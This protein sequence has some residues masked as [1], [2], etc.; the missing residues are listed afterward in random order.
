[1]EQRPSTAEQ[2]PS[3]RSRYIAGAAAAALLLSLG[4]YVMINREAR[5]PELPALDCTYFKMPSGT[6]TYLEAMVEPLPDSAFD[7]VLDQSSLVEGI[8]V[9]FGDAGPDGP[10]PIEH[11]KLYETFGHQFVNASGIE[12][13]VDVTVH[14]KPD[15]GF[16]DGHC[17]SVVSFRIDPG[18]II[19]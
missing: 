12:T 2:P 15:S 5:K 11:P 17:S 16:K 4:G 3:K 7:K 14:A 1:M 19:P 10:S 18:V 9:K 8:D 6:S 13:S